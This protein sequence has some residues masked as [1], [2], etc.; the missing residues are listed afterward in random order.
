MRRKQLPPGVF[1]KRRNPVT[2]EDSR[3]SL[4]SDVAEGG[5]RSVSDADVGIDRILSK[6]LGG[7]GAAGRARDERRSRV[8]LTESRPGPRR[9]GKPRS[10]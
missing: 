4:A 1:T 5:R 8:P 9:G 6:G 10:R 2:L 3:A 7:Y